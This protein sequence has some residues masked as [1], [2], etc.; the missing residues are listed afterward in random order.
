MD[1]RS[2]HRKYGGLSDDQFRRLKDELLK[3]VFTE[4]YAEIGRSIVSRFLW[5]CGVVLT[6][7]LTYL[8]FTGKISFK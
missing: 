3:E 4:I 1:D 2:E 7:V 6:A 5:A 8:G